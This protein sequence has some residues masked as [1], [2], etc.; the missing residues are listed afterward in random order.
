ML[1]SLSPL[2]GRH[3]DSAALRELMRDPAVRVLTITGPT[4]V[5]K[6]RLA[7]DLFHR[8]CSSF[9]DGGHYADLRAVPAGA[10]LAAVVLSSID[11]ADAS[12]HLDGQ[13]RRQLAVH[14]AN[15]ECLLVID[16]YEH[17]A[18]Q[19]AT[20]LPKLLSECP[21]LRVL[22]V[23]HEPLHIYGERLFR[24]APLEL[25]PM[26]PAPD[27]VALEGI[28]SVDFFM[29]RAKAARAGF[30][31]TPD[32]YTLVCEICRRLDGLP[33]AI[34]FAARRL[35]LYS[36]RKILADL[37]N[38]WDSLSGRP[39]DTLSRH[40][41][42]RAAVEWSYARLTDD[43]RLFMSRVAIFSGE[44][45]I[46]DAESVILEFNG[47]CHEHLEALVDKSML[48]LRED[49]DGE[50]A[51]SMLS[52]M[53]VH[54]LNELR[55][56]GKSDSLLHLLA[57]HLLRV[58]ADA[59]PRFYGPDRAQLISRLTIFHDDLRAAFRYFADR[60]E[61][62]QAAE[63]AASLRPYWLATGQASEGDSL[64]AEALDLGLDDPELL[65][66][67]MAVG[68][69]VAVQL[70]DPAAEDRLELALKTYTALD[71]CTG[72]GRCLHQ[73][74]LLADRDSS[75]STDAELLYEQATSALRNIA[76]TPDHRSVLVDLAES[77][78]I[79]GKIAEASKLAERVS[80]LSAFAADAYHSA[81]AYRVLAVVAA[82][83]GDHEHAADLCREAIRLLHC[84]RDLP[85]LAAILET[86]SAFLANIPRNSGSWAR[87]TRLLA[88]AHAT[89]HHLGYR[90]MRLL[91]TSP[92]QLCERA[93]IRLGDEAYDANRSAGQAT[94]VD[95]AV[96]EALA[97]LSSPSDTDHAVSATPLT[98]REFEVAE[99]V[100][101]GLTNREIS[102][103]LG[104]AEWTVVNHLRKI[105]RKL[106]CP[107]RVHVA[108][109]VAR[110]RDARSPA[111]EAVVMP[112]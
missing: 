20:V 43:E 57:T 29:Q 75:D 106:D 91:T 111:A 28:A 74:A 27:L 60:G 64:L 13:P 100:A 24:V 71:H 26:N 19:V 89:Y 63:L 16:H 22:V 93:R 35:K 108:N 11:P 14:L 38:E 8:I 55:R 31:L 47:S 83:R 54:A 18:D 72:I 67:V 6:S 107:S 80:R 87:S 58:A 94:S 86:L 17:L 66:R 46:S 39:T 90:P 81:R 52:T 98:P 99:L 78:L 77:Q 2:V 49:A 34:E 51:F 56:S 37:D 69:E 40:H 21:G 50:L 65:A 68:G 95:A 33:L 76:D 30:A 84:S 92:D 53:R 62:R 12:M 82:T 10:D 23:Q 36:I 32:N 73:L 48:L 45:R 96:A 15:R 97:Y 101:C 85:A 5:G 59:E 88:A 25:P 42:M 70:G 61:G 3:A 109:W 110:L 112:T 103:R 104:I 7:A 41:S 102:R 9:A 4:G 105:M 79:R 44:F 1:Y